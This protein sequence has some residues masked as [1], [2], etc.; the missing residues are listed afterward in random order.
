LLVLEGKTHYPCVFLP[1]Q[2]SSRAHPLLPG[3]FLRRNNG[4]SVPGYGTP[5]V[6]APRRRDAHLFVP[7]PGVHLYFSDCLSSI[8]R[9]ASSLYITTFCWFVLYSAR[10]ADFLF[11][12]ATRG[13]KK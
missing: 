10:F 1:P 13:G 12:V 2:R 6:R 8:E 4:S 5:G 3:L 7:G 11:V 9:F